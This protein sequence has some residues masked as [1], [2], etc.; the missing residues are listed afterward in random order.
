MNGAPARFAVG[1]DARVWGKFQRKNLEEWAEHF[2]EIGVCTSDG[3]AAKG[4]SDASREQGIGDEEL[5][6]ERDVSYS[7]GR[8]VWCRAGF[9]RG[10]SATGDGAST[11]ARSAAARAAA[12]WADAGT[13][14][15]GSRAA[16]GDAAAAAGVER[17]PDGAGAADLHGI[18]CA[19]GD[20]AVECVAGAGGSA[21][22]DDDAAPGRAGEDSRGVDAGSAGEV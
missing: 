5:F 7:S 18:A 12:E 2:A 13:A 8:A 4:C 19:N 16:R 17:Q 10:G 21:G 11:A 9:E 20:V 6:N 3:S 15:H 14:S 1:K 22:A